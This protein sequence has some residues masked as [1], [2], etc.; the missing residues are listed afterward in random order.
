MKIEL[1]DNATAAI[2]ALA[3]AA[4]LVSFMCSCASAGEPHAIVSFNDI[5]HLAALKDSVIGVC[6]TVFVNDSTNIFAIE[7]FMP[8]GKKQDS[9]IH[10]RLKPLVT[11]RE[12]VTMT[13][14][15]HAIVRE[16]GPIYDFGPGYKCI[17]GYRR[18]ITPGKAIICWRPVKPPDLTSDNNQV[19]DLELYGEPDPIAD[20]LLNYEIH[21]G[22]R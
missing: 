1:N 12:L 10:Y 16:D 8:G 3:V 13:V 9:S 14:V 17:V 2:V 5:K 20:T 15:R 18:D 22:W 21:M 11:C 4:I 7:F 6:D 19:F